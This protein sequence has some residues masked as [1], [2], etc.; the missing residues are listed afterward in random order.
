[1]L[2]Y[3]W[4]GEDMYQGLH[5]IEDYGV[6]DCFDIEDANRR[7][8]EMSEEVIVSYG[9]EKEYYDCY[10]EVE[11]DEDIEFDYGEHT[12]WEIRKIK[13][14]YVELGEDEL[15]ALCRRDPDGFVE[16]FTEEVD[17]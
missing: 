7:G 6:F 8:L 9:L 10:D 15:N 17:F 5:G 14:E 16:K 11:D 3:I 13:D 2:F 12:M 4:A 1:M